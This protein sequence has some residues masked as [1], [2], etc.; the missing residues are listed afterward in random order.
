IATA[1]TY[2]DLRKQARQ[3]ECEIDLKLVAFNKLAAG[4]KTSHTHG[5]SDTVPLL[6]E[7]DTFDTMAMEI[8]QLLNKLSQ[9]NE[10]MSEQPVS[11]VAM[12]HTIQR[13][14]DIAAD[15]QRDFHKTNSQFVSRRE[16]EELFKNVRTDSFRTEGVNR[17]DMYLK[18]NTHIQNSDQLVNEQIAIAM[19]TKDH[20]LN[21][22]QTFKRMQTRFNDISHRFPVINSLVQRINL[23]KRRDAIIL[24]SVIGICTFLLLMYAFH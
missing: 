9:V 5:S 22:R 6:S 11:G 15:L 18:E 23:R 3:L 14:R 7:E 24:G 21:Q 12:M 2:E 8:Q 1:M 16:R 20:L 10:R 4:V 13:H 17:R 19:E